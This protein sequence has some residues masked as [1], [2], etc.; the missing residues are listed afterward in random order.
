LGSYRLTGSVVQTG[1]AAGLGAAL[2]INQ[3]VLPLELAGKKLVE[4]LEALRA[5]FPAS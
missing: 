5:E 1:E 4:R 2:G 3:N